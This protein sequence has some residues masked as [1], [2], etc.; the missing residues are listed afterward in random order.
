ML[1]QR[2][3]ALCQCVLQ[4]VLN[5]FYL[6]PF[7][8]PDTEVF[9]GPP[10]PRVNLPANTDQR[11]SVCDVIFWKW[12]KKFEFQN[13]NISFLGKRNWKNEKKYEND[14]ILMVL[15]E[16]NQNCNVFLIF[17]KFIFFASMIFCKF[18]INRK[19]WFLGFKS[20]NVKFLIFFQKKCD[21]HRKLLILTLFFTFFR[22]P[23]AH[24][25]R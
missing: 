5:D 13:L 20:K 16:K 6:F 14:W 12:K 8:R 1:F 9:E 3:T 10:H 22:K 11:R 25:E 18:I 4:P 23:K 19:M 24:S 2:G 17:Q 7:R 15:D 21:F